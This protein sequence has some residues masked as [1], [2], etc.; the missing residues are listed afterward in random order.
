MGDK[1]FT[2]YDYEKAASAKGISFKTDSEGRRHVTKTV[3]EAAEQ[4]MR[5]T[6]RP[7][8][9]VDPASLGVIRRS[10]IRFNPLPDGTFVCTM[11]TPIAKA[12]YID[13]TGSMGDNNDTTMAVL[14]EYFGVAKEVLPDGLYDLQL[15]VSIFG[16]V[17]HDKFGLC[18]PQFEMEAEKIV[19]YVSKM[20]PERDGG[21]GPED[22]HYAA[23]AHA[24][25]TDDYLRRAGLKDYFSMVT[26]AS[27]HEWDYNPYIIEKL[28]GED[29]WKALAENGHPEIT[30]RNL[31]SIRET[32]EELHAHSH[33]FVIG[34]DHVGYGGH[35][36]PR[37]PQDMGYGEYFD[38]NHQLMI[39]DTRCLPAVDAAIIGLTEGT[40]QPADVK[41][42]LH[43]HQVSELNI[44]RV[45]P[46]L[47]RVPFR[48][49]RV[50]EQESKVLTG[51]LPKRGD[52]FAD[53]NDINPIR[54]A[55]DVPAEADVQPVGETPTE[56]SGGWL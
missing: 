55:E 46:G 16:D 3:S 30:R 33:A 14:P 32:F 49:Q 23:F 6:G 51:S 25:L 41:M 45:L 53:K 11:G 7:P 9:E 54:R 42:F 8:Y 1:S 35:H 21:D 44:E 19:D 38:R 15:A 26:D 22:P 37:D 40:L 56:D 36:S 43:D 52:I 10:L 17:H 29:V 27:M 5:K 28:F 31:P 39:A 12:S 24:Y 48:A 20:T 50:L 4:K 2:T 47:L 34:V 18:R 13:T